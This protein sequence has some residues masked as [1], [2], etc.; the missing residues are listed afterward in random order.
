MKR[1]HFVQQTALSGSALYFIPSL[2]LPFKGKHIGIQLYSVR[3]VVVADP[4]GTLAK[5]SAMG[6]TEIEGYLYKNGLFH[7]FPPK[8]F[9]KVLSDLGMRLV[10]M[11]HG[12]NMSHWD[13]TYNRLSD[14]AQKV[15]DDHAAMGVDLLI[16]PSLEESEKAHE[17][18]KRLCDVFNHMGEACK[19]AGI[20]FGYHNHDY[21]FTSRPKGNLMETLLQ[22]TDPALVSWEMDLYWVEYAGQDPVQWIKR[23]PGR[24]IAFHVKD[25]ADSTNRET[26]VVG[27]GLI[28]FQN[29]F[30]LRETGSVKYYIVELEHYTTTSLNGV[31]RSLKN[32]KQL[33]S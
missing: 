14:T 5:L 8:V 2:L 4:A 11:H 13:A 18:L 6:Y 21:E 27:D 17:P 24:I 15:I 7:S 3:D 23:N 25:L 33:L 26:A 29:I 28:D 10:S 22:H 31:E 1:R 9:K 19:K 30:D 20:Q 32:L 16:C 12:I